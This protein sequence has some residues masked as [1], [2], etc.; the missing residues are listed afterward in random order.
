MKSLLALV[1][2]QI[3]IPGW[4]AP[5]PDTTPQTKTF[6][7][8][9]DTS[10]TT[11][12]APAAVIEHYRKLFE[13]AGLPFVANSD[14]LGTN[15]RASAPECDLLLSIRPQS[16]GSSVK[17]NCASKTP[18]YDT[19]T[20]SITTTPAPRA[21]VARRIPPTPADMMARHNKLVAEMGIHRVYEDVPAP[22]LLWPDWLVHV[23]GSRLS[24]DR[25]VDQ[26]H[27][28][29][30]ESKYTSTVPMTSIY[31]FYKDLLR[32]NGYLVHSSELGTGQT[33][34]GIRQNAQGHVEGTNYPN[35]SPGPRT[36]IRV[37]FSR[38]YLNEP[39]T[40]RIRFTT[41]PFEAPKR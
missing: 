35:G 32:A 37:N 25:G 4:L 8:Y 12:A 19:E 1:L 3:S 34:R 26:S 24:Y 21:G 36:V 41:Y 20:S 10:Y 39:I 29:Y 40:V 9:T 28:Q 14:G 23:S 31:T 6:P 15:V 22:P 17:L 18:S 13:T 30:L 11:P 7:A 38:F 16:T 33:T 2:A 27:Q 5:F